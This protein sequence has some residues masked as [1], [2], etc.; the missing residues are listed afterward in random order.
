[1]IYPAKFDRRHDLSVA[2]IYRLNNLWNLSGVFIFTS[3][4]AFTMPVGRYII[5]GNLVNEYGNVNNFRM[6]AYHRL[7]LSATR[8][9]ITPKGNVSSWNFSIYNVYNRANPFYIYFE[10]TGN[11]EEYR[12]DIEPVMMS[13]FP[14]IPSVSWRFEF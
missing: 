1:M 9:R 2:G 11:L 5:Q 12:L 4:N 8:T 6:P 13:L 10:A 7:D 14:I 3:G